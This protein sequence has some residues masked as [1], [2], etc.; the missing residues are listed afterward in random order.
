MIMTLYYFNHDKNADM[1]TAFFAQ[2]G[3]TAEG[4]QSVPQNGDA[5]KPRGGD[6]IFVHWLSSKAWETYAKDNPMVDLVV[7]SRASITRDNQWPMNIHVCRHSANSFGDNSKVREFVEAYKTDNIKKWEL[8]EPSDYP[9]E[10]VAWYLV[11]IAKDK[12]ID[13]TGSMPSDLEAKAKNSFESIRSRFGNGNLLFDRAGI[14]KLLQCVT[15]T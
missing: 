6:V 8:I 3:T 14:A 4:L 10:L 11:M 12:G 15:S 9:E 7:I 2:K 1:I 5:N 13:V